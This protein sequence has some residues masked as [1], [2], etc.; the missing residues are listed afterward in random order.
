MTSR[1]LDSDSEALKGRELL[2]DWLLRHAARK[3]P[4][5]LAAR[6][7]EE[8]RADLASRSSYLS[9]LRFALGCCWAIQVIAYEHRPSPAAAA[10][11]T[12]GSALLAFSELHD[13]GFYSRR[14]SSF[15]VVLAV[16]L[17]V[18]YALLTWVTHLHIPPVV[19]SLVPTIIKREPQH[20]TP[21][22]TPPDLGQIDHKMD[23][24][25][26][27]FPPIDPGV[28]ELTTQ[29][30][31]DPL[32]IDNSPP[33]P[34]VVTRVMGGAGAGF[35]NVEEFYP[36]P[37]IRLAHQGAVT[38]TVCVNPNGKLSSKPTVA[39]PSGFD[40]LDQAAVTL[41]QA[42]SGHYRATTEDGQ[43][44]SSCYPLRI[45]FQLRN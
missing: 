3:A 43:P 11:T 36:A 35:P 38:V 33:A 1:K 7:E 21:K 14:G 5:D 32:V 6:L 29:V 19:Q 27:E 42:G 40:G 24:P 45:R 44:V 9:R 2:N 17:A 30:L 26:I 39:T 13:A 4:A 10:A 25:V 20:D 22:P 34:H 28:P 37:E 16:H 41:A 15:I 8:W 31:K 23:L 18:F 12:G